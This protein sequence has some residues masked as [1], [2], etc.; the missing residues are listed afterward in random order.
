MLNDFEFKFQLSEPER[1]DEETEAENDARPV[2]NVHHPA[3]MYG[4]IG[5]T[6]SPADLN[7]LERGRNPLVRKWWIYLPPH[8]PR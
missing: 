4:A 1:S 6:T 8:L 5:M 2:L 7:P 3:T